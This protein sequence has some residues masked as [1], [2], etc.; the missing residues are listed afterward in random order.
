VKLQTGSPGEAALLAATW[1]DH[2]GVVGWLSAIDHKTIGRRFIVTAF[3]FFV[4][5]GLLA[6]LMRIQLARPDSTL[7]G[8]DLY[9]QLFTMHGTTMMFLFA[10]PVMEAMAV[11]FVPLLVGARNIAFP[12][13]NAYSYW[14]YLFGGVMLYVRDCDETYRRAIEAGA[15]SLMEPQDMFWGDRYGKIEDPFGH[16]WGIGTAK[17]KVS[18]KEVARRLSAQQPPP[19]QG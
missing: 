3:G 1:R 2:D 12:R 15:R 19:A 11:Y 10:V 17:E 18:A 6:A 14:I 9:N 7:I 16:Y 4:A 13:M 8:P 5:A